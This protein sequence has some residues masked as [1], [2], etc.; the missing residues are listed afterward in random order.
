[1]HKN[2]SKNL[3]LVWRIEGKTNCI[4]EKN[5]VGRQ[6]GTTIRDKRIHIKIDTFMDIEKNKIQE[7][8]S[9]NKINNLFD[10]YLYSL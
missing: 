3:D 5:P 1:M 10:Y 7:V 6:K 2:Q 9:F 8:L 4:N